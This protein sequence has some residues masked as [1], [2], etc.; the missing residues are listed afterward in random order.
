[1]ADPRTFVL[2]GKFDDQIT[3]ALEKI[4]NSISQL[5]SNLESLSKVTKPIKTDFKKLADLSKTFSSG[6]KT[7]A[8]DIRDITAAMRSMRNEMGRVNRAYR[9]AGRNRNIAPPPPPPPRIPRT[10]RFAAPPPPPPPPPTPP[11][12]PRG[13]GR[14]AEPPVYGRRQA[15]GRES[16]LG[17]VISGNL[18]SNAIIQGFQVG[19]GILQQGMAAAFGAFAERAKDQLEDIGAAGG[20]FSA[21]QFANIPGFPKT[22]Q[23]AM[24]MQDKINKD[25]ATIASNLPGTTH[26]YV[27]NSRRL[28]DTT[29]QIMARDMKGFTKLAIELTGKMNI[30]AEEAF[31]VVNVEVAKATTMLEKLNPAKTVVPMTQLVEDMLKD[32]KVT[33][34]GLRR[35]VSFRRST[36]F[37]AALQ[38][39]IDELNKTGAGTAARL[40][41]IIKVLK[42]AAPPEMVGAF[43]ASVSGV[44]EGF[45]S[46]LMDPDVGIFGLSRQLTFQVEKFDRETGK[47]IG[48]E[49]TNF[50][51]MF[52][53]VFGNLGNL[54]N[55][56]ILPGLQALYQPFD[57]IAKQ[58]ESLREYSYKI[59]ERQQQYN[60]YFGELA[61]KYGMRREDFKVFEK[62]GLST[63]MNVLEGFGMLDRNKYLKYVEKM[64][65]KGTPEEV[66]KNMKEIYADIIPTVFKSP[67]F[68]EIGKTLGN[69]LA[70]VFKEIA[71]IMKAL[72]KGDYGT[73]SFLKA[74]Y[75][76]GG[77]DAINEILMYVAEGIGKLLLKIAEVYMGALAKAIGSGNFA[78]AGVL[79]ALGLV[80]GAP[81]IAGIKIIASGMKMLVNAFKF[82]LANAA[83]IMP[84]KQVK[85]SDVG[86]VITD[87]S[88]MLPAAKTAGELPTS[89]INPQVVKGIGAFGKFMEYFRGV[90]PRFLNFFKG[91]FGKLAILGGVLT[92]VTSLFQGKDLATSLAEGAGP[93]LGAALG[94]A[95]IPFL[96]P[97]G[98]MIGSLIGSWVGS[99]K[100]VTDFLTGV[101][102]GI[103]WGL[104]TAWSAIQ[105]SLEAI[106][107]TFKVYGDIFVSLIP[108][109]EGVSSGLD[110]LN[111]AFI[112]T[113]ISLYPVI[114]ALNATALAL[115]VFQLALLKFDQWLNNTFQWGDRKGR[116]Q[117]KINEVEKSIGETLLRQQRLN[118]DIFKP[119][120]DQSKKKNTTLTEPVT[121]AT[122]PS[123]SAFGGMFNQPEK[124]TSTSLSQ[125]LASAP[126]PAKPGPPPPTSLSQLLA[127]APKPLPTA[128][129]TAPVPVS[130]VPPKATPPAVVGA[131]AAAPKEIAQTAANTQELNQKASAQ[132]TQ[133]AGIRVAAQQTQKNTTVSNTT[134][135]NIRS[136]I[137]AVSNRIG[138]L[139]AAMLRDLNNIEAGVASISSLLSSGQLKVQGAGPGN[140]PMGTATG[141]LGRAQNLASQYGLS[142]T[143]YFRAGDKGYHGLGRAMDFSNGVSTPQQMEFAQAMVAQYGTSLK[144]LIYTPLGFG[145]KDGVK[146][147]L[148]YW[149]PGTNLG[150]YDH[151]HVAFANGP[152]DGRMFTQ[153]G[154]PYGAQSWE[155]SMVPGSV[156]VASITGNSGEGFGGETSVVNNFTITQQP[157]EDGEALANRVATL[158]YDA[159]NNAQSASIFG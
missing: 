17:D 53:E 153:M 111:I 55:N 38:R 113:K 78:A 87:P 136:G 16:V 149:G 83:K 104:Q 94:A 122:P 23:G 131:V 47:R 151:V 42:E 56:S 62:A 146:V 135:G 52:S 14:G 27:E 147:P 46:A 98:P 134:L 126:K 51:K 71:K 100:P 106:G 84:I 154:G 119:L 26:D 118:M 137:M 103:G 95:L 25:M 158:F 15:P 143:S 132:I 123:V 36:T 72:L 4:N 75:D 112:A 150:H 92:T 49:Y 74:F 121:T 44:V 125:L 24:D 50:F 107:A 68:K 117:D 33:I 97:I 8:S 28:V 114:T 81:A 61:A 93:V 67:F 148:S 65:A 58:F 59:F 101:F 159:M 105:P 116:I 30:S 41:M 32:E 96:G 141:N 140:G 77:M 31:R 156:K 138:M 2:I 66:A 70:N 37:E 64:K 144:E 109:F 7:Q 40:K 39:N 76:A 21:S 3:P 128:K 110:L 11:R 57:A 129:P 86:S 6:L 127:S 79:G 12:Y 155:R 48:K 13:Y 22:F 88:R 99:L 45:K 1:M 19:V 10:P 60:A 139:Q 5:K 115:Q 108:G 82:L 90:G 152:Q 35:Y 89:A 29:A 69:A 124:A 43:Q 73:N 9:A 130:P 142:L 20:I 85:V 18:I 80:F 102:K 145:I 34:G 91:F 133:A 54:I 157:G 63:L 120:E